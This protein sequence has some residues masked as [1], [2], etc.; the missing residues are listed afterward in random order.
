MKKL[1]SLLIISVIIFLTACSSNTGIKTTEAIISNHKIYL[2]V[3]SA[4]NLLFNTYDIDVYI[5]KN[6]VGVVTNGNLLTALVEISEGKH[7]ITVYNA[8]D[9]SVSA[10]NSI[11]IKE[12][13]TFT[14]TLGHGKDITFQDVSISKGIVNSEI[15]IPN[16]TEMILSEAI[17]KLDGAGFKNIQKE[18]SS[19]I[20]DDK[21][22]I[23][24]KQSVAGGQKLI[25][26][27]QYNLIAPS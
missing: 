16:V 13:I 23:I 1:F 12:D 24:I 6:K 4:S 11:D 19:E 21:N 8:K 20:W 15:E 9:Y 3:T 14:C 2:D 18:P 27:H 25:K 10:T 22:W 5:D 7:Q 17:M 26:T